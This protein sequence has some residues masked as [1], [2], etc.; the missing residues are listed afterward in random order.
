[1][2]LTIDSNQLGNALG[3]TTSVVE[4][5][6]TIPILSNV[7]MTAKDGKLYL[8][9]TDMDLEVV[10]AAPAQIEAEGSTTVPA[11]TLHDIIRKLPGDSTVTLHLNDDKTMMDITCGRSEFRLGCLPKE[12]F[13]EMTQSETENS[14]SIPGTTLAKMIDRTKFAISTEETRYYLNGIY[15]HIAETPEGKVLRA[16]ATDGH[17]LARYETSMPDNAT[18]MPG[19]IIPRKTITELRKLLDETGDD[20]EVHFS[21]KLIQF[22]FGHT[23]LTSKLIDGTFP[24]Y[25][26]VIPQ[27]NNKVLEVNPE[28]FSK[29]VDRV[30]TIA[31]E[32]TRAVKLSI[33]G[34]TMTL[35]A[36]N[37][38][39]G[40]ATEEL[41]IVFH[42]NETID[43][44]FNARYLLDVTSLL[45]GNCSIVLNDSASPTII[46]DN[47]DTSSLFVLMPMRV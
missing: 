29:A 31:A 13:P 40:T 2:K 39:S 35:T 45:D 37:T 7:L 4:K 38:E 26:R 21:D 30:S 32:K 5:R 3:H 24:D 18:A 27:N 11:H 10:D 25:E 44:G 17:R 41:E 14:F 28:A 34:Q 43:I 6:T 33:Q 22:T 42:A 36:S 1:M 12:D 20:I 19:M 23:K 16:V 47:K 15:F 9:A 8:C 46:Q